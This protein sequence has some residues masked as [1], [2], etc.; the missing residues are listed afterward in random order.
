VVPVDGPDFGD[1]RPDVLLTAGLILLRVR[2][3]ITDTAVDS[4]LTGSWTRVVSGHFNSLT[5]Q[6]LQ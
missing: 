5:L 1:E 4:G 6:M 3:L 2:H